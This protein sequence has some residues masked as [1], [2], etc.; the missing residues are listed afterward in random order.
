MGATAPQRCEHL[1]VDVAGKI[2]N[3]CGVT[4]EL[5]DD[6][7]AELRS[8]LG[9]EQRAETPIE[10]YAREMERSNGSVPIQS[11]ARA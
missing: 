6:C 3:A 8:R 4:A 1:A 7:V 5:C 11:K 10:A 9:T 2:F